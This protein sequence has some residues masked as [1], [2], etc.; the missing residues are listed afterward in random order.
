M[1]ARWNNLDDKQ[2]RVIIS[3][4]NIEVGISGTFKNSQKFAVS[5]VVDTHF[6]EIDPMFLYTQDRCTTNKDAYIRGKTSGHRFFTIVA[7]KS[8][9]GYD[10]CGNAHKSH[11]IV[12]IVNL[13]KSLSKI[14]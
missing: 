1:I 2:E 9:R 13:K 12:I 4:I 10:L 7:V 3:K 14:H 8:S 11:T 6:C 5:I